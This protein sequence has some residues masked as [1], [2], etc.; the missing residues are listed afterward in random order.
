MLHECIAFSNSLVGGSG[1][2]FFEDVG[3][4]Q[5]CWPDANQVVAAMEKLLPPFFKKI[6]AAA[7][8]KR[9]KLETINLV[10]DNAAVFNSK[11]V[12]SALQRLG[13]TRVK[14][15]PA[16]SSDLM[17]QEQVWRMSGAALRNLGFVDGPSLKRAMRTAYC[18]L[19]TSEAK[20][21]QIRKLAA[22]FKN[23]LRRCIAAGG[24]KLKI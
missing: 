11:T 14:G 1:V 15:Y 3:R 23:R 21:Q 12:A 18:G 24:A 9:L 7:R 13:A 8:A 5:S 4:G 2:V 17:P 6:R 19:I 16:W 10:L 22:G 20:Q